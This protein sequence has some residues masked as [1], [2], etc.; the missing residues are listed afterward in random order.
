MN[1]DVT[2]MESNFFV[3]GGKNGK[4]KKRKN[5]IASIGYKRLL[6]IVKDK[7]QQ[8][9][10]GRSTGSFA[11]VNPNVMKVMFHSFDSSGDGELSRDEF[12]NALRSRLGLMN[13]SDKDMSE[14][15]DHFDADGDGK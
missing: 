7:I 11:T 5:N 10:R 1:K 2:Q 6:E 4:N 14:L 8:K 15:M 3:G 9:V 12:S 13:I